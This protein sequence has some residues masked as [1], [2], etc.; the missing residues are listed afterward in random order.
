MTSKVCVFARVA[1]REPT[2]VGPNGRTSITSPD[3][4]CGIAMTE[5]LS[6]FNVHSPKEIFLAQLPSGVLCRGP[7]MVSHKQKSP[8]WAQ[9]TRRPTT[10]KRNSFDGNAEKS[11]QLLRLTNRTAPKR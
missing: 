5:F 10:W 2:K 6:Y 9:W 11:T 3:G 7:L 4:A 1:V 8:P